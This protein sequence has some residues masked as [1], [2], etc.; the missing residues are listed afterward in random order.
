LKQPHGSLDD[1]DVSID[2]L[3]VPLFFNFLDISAESSLVQLVTVTMRMNA[4]LSTPTQ[5]VS[6]DYEELE[7]SPLVAKVT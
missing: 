4:T 6:P 2:E 3:D 7:P 5:G 1:I